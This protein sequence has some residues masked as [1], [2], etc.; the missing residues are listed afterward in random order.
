M[1]RNVSVRERN[2]SE[3]FDRIGVK[4][5]EMSTES[6]FIALASRVFC[7]YLG[8]L[9]CILR[10]GINLRNEAR[11]SRPGQYKRAGRMRNLVYI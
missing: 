10:R 6:A 7:T 1:W 3:G 2:G 9:H 8:D 4:L 11:E 5:T